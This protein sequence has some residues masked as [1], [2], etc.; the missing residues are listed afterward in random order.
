MLW[1]AQGFG[2]GRIRGGPGT[3]GSLAGLVWFFVLAWPENVWI[4]LAGCT[5]TAA[6]SVWLCG[7]A[8]KIL[9]QKDPASVVLD[10]IAAVPLCFASW[11]CIV[12]SAEGHW[13]PL[14]HFF[15]QANWLL[16]ISLFAGF[17]LFD[18]V[19]PWP[20]RQIQSLPAGWGITADDLLAAAYV[21][22]IFILGWL[23]IAT[24]G[25]TV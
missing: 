3:V 14:E 18:I 10:E 23:A 24:F 6:G 5:A 25:G 11:I 8:E 9:D 2:A 7:A 1:A 21:N 22:L 15:S 4:F 13:P 19:K 20:V 17:R 16:I 12:A